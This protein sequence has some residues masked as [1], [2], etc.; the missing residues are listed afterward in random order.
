MYKSRAFTL[1]E[2]LFALLILQVLLLAAVGTHTKAIQLQLN[3]VQR[4]LAVAAA[5]DLV[6]SLRLGEGPAGAVSGI[7]STDTV[8]APVYCLPANPCHSSVIRNYLL[9]H[10]QLSWLDHG[11][12]KR[13]YNPRF[14]LQGSE[15]QLIVEVSW[16]QI[17][18]LVNTGAEGSADSVSACLPE[19]GRS[20][21]RVTVYQS[22]L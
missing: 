17:G 16:R 12:A 22:P 18:V 6:H 2:V 8:L 19:T 13:L 7:Y 21:F 5:T 20:G 1:P 11:A 4:T 14:C 9:Y 3:A 10:W 15:A